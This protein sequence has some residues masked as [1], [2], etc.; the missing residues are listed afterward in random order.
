[1]SVTQEAMAERL[2]HRPG[3]DFAA[4]LWFMLSGWCLVGLVYTLAGQ[5]DLARATVLQPG[6]IDRWFAHDARAFWPYMSFFA[7]VPMGFFASPLADARWLCRAFQISALGA[8]LVYVIFP[9]TMVFPPVQQEGI[10]A[11]ALELLMRHD[12]LLNCLPSLHVTLTV[13]ALA[14]VWR[15]FSGWKRTGAALWAA[16]IMLSIPILARH[17]MVDMLAGL[18]LALLAGLLAREGR[19]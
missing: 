18:G 17:Q 16:A 15:G 10:S 1:M 7:F 2:T 5:Q 12:V 6:A 4:R 9:T 11:T 8:G 19:G 14:A 13:L 3:A